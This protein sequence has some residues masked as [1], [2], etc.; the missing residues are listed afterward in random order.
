M[1]FQ[2][3][4]ELPTDDRSRRPGCARFR[5][6]RK[7]LPALSRVGPDRSLWLQRQSD[8]VLRSGRLEGRFAMIE[9]GTERAVVVGI[10]ASEASLAAVRWAAE[11]AVR[12]ECV[13]RIFHAGLFDAADLAPRE[14]PPDDEA[15]LLLEH[16]HGWLW[17]AAVVAREAAPEVRVERCVG[18]GLAVDLLVG[19]SADVPLVVVGSHGLGGVRGAV[20]GSVALRVAA[21]AHCAVVVV[22]G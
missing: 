18:L 6:R 2:G 17:R 9:T 10:D 1:C 12:R 4:P 7:G 20:I 21:A 16:V 11:E 8:P 5:H 13:L 22:R 15:E 19:M 3:R 14:N